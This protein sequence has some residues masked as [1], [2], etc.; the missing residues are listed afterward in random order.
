MKHGHETRYKRIIKV[1]NLDY[2]GFFSFGKFVFKFT[3]NWCVDRGIFICKL[4][5]DVRFNTEVFVFHE[6]MSRTFYVERIFH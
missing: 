1:K 3:M 4:Y 2:N 6:S 5:T